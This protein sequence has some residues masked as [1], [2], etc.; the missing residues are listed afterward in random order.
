MVVYSY[1]VVFSFFTVLESALSVTYWLPFY[2]IFKFA[3]IMWLGLPQ[4]G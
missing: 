1:W 2:Y 3:L 4:L